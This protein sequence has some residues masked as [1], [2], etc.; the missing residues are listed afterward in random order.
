VPS[1]GPLIG[2][3]VG[4]G[5][6]PMADSVALAVEAERAGLDLISIGDSGA[7]TF[8]LLGA[9]AAST[10]EIGLLSGVAQWTRSPVTLAHGAKTLQC[11]SGGRYR[12]GI[13]PM[14]RDWSIDHHGLDYDPVL[15]R[16]R[17]YLAATRAALAATPDAP[18]AHEGPYFRSVGF[19]G[20]P[21]VPQA[22][23]AIELAATRPRMTAL[24]AEIAD[25]VMLNT[26]QPTEWLSG[27]GA[28][29]IADGLARSGRTRDQLRVGLLRAVAIDDDRAVAYD[30]ARR[31]I[32][33]YFAIPYFRA[34]LEPYGFGAE[35]DAGEA[36]LA[37]GDADAQA[38]AV[39]DALVD[40][41][42]LAGTPTEVVAKLARLGGLVD[43]VVLTAVLDHGR[44]AAH[45]QTMRLIRTFAPVAHRSPE[46]E[47]AFPT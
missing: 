34:L 17:D 41:V 18:T 23:I 10:S 27:T 3:S 20:H 19:G 22:P 47:G 24:A 21:M 35:L 26:I 1:E 33:F 38:A 11:L 12:L 42:A 15:G 46:P 36:A 16:M 4:H 9:I 5:S 43:Y 2:L 37:A 40:A 30:H 6:A 14:P 39:S 7:E 31:S 45:E 13:G 25:G 44:E 28:E 8:A 29:A 32:A